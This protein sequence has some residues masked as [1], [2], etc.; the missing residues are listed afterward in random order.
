MLYV[1]DFLCVLL[2]PES[3]IRN[4]IGKHFKLK[5]TLIGEPDIYLGGKVRKVEL[6]SDAE[7]WAFGSSQY[8]QEA[9]RNVRK[10]PKE[11]HDKLNDTDENFLP[12][13]AAKGPLSNGYRPEIDVTPELDEIDTVYYQSLIGV[14]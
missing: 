8:I 4:Q 5:E 2:D 10:C 6:D 7:C 3:I 9:C 14:L 12:K 13:S 1:D 11:R